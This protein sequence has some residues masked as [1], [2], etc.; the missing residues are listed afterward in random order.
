[1][2]PKSDLYFEEKRLMTVEKLNVF[3]WLSS[4]QFSHNNIYGTL[5]RICQI[6]KMIV[7]A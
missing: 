1:M 7:A 4:L 2:G 5:A 3:S 6:L